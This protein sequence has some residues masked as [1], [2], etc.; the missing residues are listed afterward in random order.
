MHE[1]GFGFRKRSSEKVETPLPD[2]ERS[3]WLM[4][5]PFIVN[6]LIRKER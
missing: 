2:E 3:L 6:H 5:T 1:E 4:S